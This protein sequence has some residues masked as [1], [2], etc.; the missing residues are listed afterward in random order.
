MRNL[1]KVRLS[2]VR[3]L[4]AAAILVAAACAD[5]SPTSPPASAPG[6]VARPTV[7]FGVAAVP[8]TADFTVTPSGGRFAI[9]LHTVSFPVNSICDPASSTYGPTEWDA[10]CRALDRPIQIHAEMR[11]ADGR[12]WV[13]FSPSLRFVPTSDPRQY[14]M[15]TMRRG[16]ASSV[17]PI[18]WAAYLGASGVDDAAGDPTLTTYAAADGVSE[19]RRIKHFTGYV[20]STGYR[21]Y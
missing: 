1:N 9:G 20:I 19:Y 12:S 7:A 18:L 2:A 11:S 13:D 5:R 4:T 6:A 16:V 21:L 15:L 10:P 3:L 8:T 14:V 17:T